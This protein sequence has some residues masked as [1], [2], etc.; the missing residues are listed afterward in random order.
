MLQW[1]LTTM[2][3]TLFAVSIVVCALLLG[4]GIS[5]VRDKTIWR[6]LQLSGAASLVIVVFTHVAEALHALPGMGWGMPNSPGHYLDLV[7]AVLGLTLLPLGCATT[8]LL[9]RKNSK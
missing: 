7:S 3:L 6:F 4:S 2:K 8:L 5:F 9:R 1:L